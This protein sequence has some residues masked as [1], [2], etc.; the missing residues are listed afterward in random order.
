LNVE[1][2][3]QLHRRKA[4]GPRETPAERGIEGKTLRGK[5]MGEIGEKEGYCKRKK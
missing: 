5:K 4:R 1:G 2:G 3:P